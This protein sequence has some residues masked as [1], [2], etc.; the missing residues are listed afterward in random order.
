MWQFLAIKQN[1]IIQL[2]ICHIWYIPT[3]LLW[4][5]NQW[6]QFVVTFWGYNDHHM[7]I[8]GSYIFRDCPIIGGMR[9]WGSP[10]EDMNYHGSKFSGLAPSYQDNS[11]MIL[12]WDYEDP[13]IRI[14]IWGYEDMMIPI[15]GYELSWFKMFRACPLIPGQ[16]DDLIWW[17]SSYMRI[18][19]SS[20]EDMRIL[21]WG[22]EDMMIPIWGYKVPRFKTFRACPIMQGL[23]CPDVLYL[24]QH[25]LALHSSSMVIIIW[26][27]TKLLGNI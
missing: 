19:G 25:H 3:T 7:R 26:K 10:Y 4:F 24:L 14:L 15:W 17:L 13:H 20:Y 2:A 1:W 21:T 6:W 16:F 27:E 8:W 12:I 9:I 18:W 11:M 23:R 22:Y 5:L